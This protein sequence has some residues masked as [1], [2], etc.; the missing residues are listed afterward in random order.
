ME[1]LQAAVFILTQKSSGEKKCVQGKPKLALRSAIACW[2]YRVPHS[3]L[4]QWILSSSLIADPSQHI[5]FLLSIYFHRSTDF[6]S[7]PPALAGLMVLSV[8]DAGSPQHGI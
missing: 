6:A 5:F 2:P 7:G 4:V 1:S 3:G 8:V